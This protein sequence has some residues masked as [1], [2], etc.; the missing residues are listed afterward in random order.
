MLA[1]TSASVRELVKA[2]KTVEEVL[3]ARPTAAFDEKQ[4]WAFITPERY[5]RI[6]YRDAAGAAAVK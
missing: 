2:G 5:V 4:T 1:V 6:L 3:A